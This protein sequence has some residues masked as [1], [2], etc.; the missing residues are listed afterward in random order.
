MSTVWGITFDPLLP[1]PWLVV[2]SILAL[3]QIILGLIHLKR[4]SLTRLALY[5]FFLVLFLNPIFHKDVREPVSD[6]VVLA[7]DSST[8][9]ELGDRQQQ[10]NEITA[11]LREQLGKHDDID[12]E[13][14]TTRQDS[15]SLVTTS[16]GGGT[17]LMGAINEKLSDIAPTRLAAVIAITDG[18]VHDADR[19]ALPNDLE[20]PFTFFS[21][22]L[23]QIEIAGL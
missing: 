5:G 4:Q 16:L 3:V 11:H 1:N 17:N 7:I 13:I 9:Q 2:L 12:I 6:V 10:T 14:V 21:L 22:D 20:A 8:S 15:Q 18:Q 23:A 19:S